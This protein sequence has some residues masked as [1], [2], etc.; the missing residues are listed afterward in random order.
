MKKL[1]SNVNDIATFSKLGFLINKKIIFHF[2][3]F[4]MHCEVHIL[5]IL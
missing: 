2:Y 3:P 4:N 1:K 5:K